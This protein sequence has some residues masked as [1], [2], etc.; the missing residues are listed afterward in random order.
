MTLIDY[1]VYL[2][3]LISI[4]KDNLY[5]VLFYAYKSNLVFSMINL[6]NSTHINIGGGSDFINDKGG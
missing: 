5:I 4:I 3:L 1:P 2:Y 6:I